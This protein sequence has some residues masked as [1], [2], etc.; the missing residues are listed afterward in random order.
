[1]A[2][3]GKPPMI[4]IT[5]LNNKFCKI[6]NA[7]EPLLKRLRRVLS[8]KQ[9]GYEFSYQH[10]NY[11]W[12]GTIYLMGKKNE[13]ALGL[14]SK[15]KEFLI[16]NQQQFTIDDQR[17]P[18]PFG[19]EIDIADK[20]KQL[21]T[22]PRDYQIEIL[23]ACLA[24]DKGIIRSCT[25]SGKTTCAA[26]IT[27]KMNYPANIYVIGLDLLQQFY[28]LFMEIFDEPIGFIGNGK[29][30]VHR[31]NIVS[32][33]TAGRALGVKEIIA[34]DEEVGD[35]EEDNSVN[36]PKII[37]CLRAAKLHMFDE[38]HTITSQTIK[39]IYEIIDPERIYGL[40]G[41]PFRDD[42]TTL[43]SN[44]ILGEQIID[45]P[46]SRLIKAGYLAQPIIK[47]IKVPKMHIG[48]QPNYQTIYK[49]YITENII[50]NNLIVENT[51][52]LLTK[53]YQVLV[54]FKH[55]A[56]GKN[57][58]ELFDEAEI[59]YEYLSGKDQLDVRIEAKNRLSNKESNL[60]L[61]STIYDIGVNI[62]TLSALVLCGS[63]RS[64]I[65]SL[66]RCGRILR[67]LPGKKFAAIVDFYDDVKYLKNHSKI[68]YNIYKSEDGFKII[69]SPELNKLLT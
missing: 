36:Y 63:G 54:L 7:E 52:E 28:N 13:F 37:K 27:A 57:L 17:V 21:K 50:R 38:C 65:K 34:A 5:I 9:A 29:C 45:V 42:G 20:L 1:V 64:T 23:N 53:G 58:K 41:T 15:V 14:L 10:K 33:W 26:M 4:T 8:Y 56:H 32:I 61:A 49:E 12:D 67:P 40:S 59:A 44:S 31:I 35:E 47:F 16:A 11:N 66:Q 69:N 62:P 43:L 3:Q 25:G 24:N 48:G 60:I 51:K 39:T 55:L 2:T 22:I 30:E 6:T 18:V 19:Q 68:R 46:A